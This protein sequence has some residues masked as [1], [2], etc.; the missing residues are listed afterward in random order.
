LISSGK[1]YTNDEKFETFSDLCIEIWEI[2][3]E[4]QTKPEEISEIFP[5]LAFSLMLS[6]QKVCCIE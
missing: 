1:F 5:L 2:L 4:I 6:Y 3:R